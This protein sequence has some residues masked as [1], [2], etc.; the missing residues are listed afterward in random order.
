M[1]NR[2]LRLL[3]KDQK[4]IILLT[5]DTAQNACKAMCERRVGSVLVADRQGE[6]AG[7]FTGRDAVRLLGTAEKPSAATLAQVMTRNP[8]TM[9]PKRRAID[10]LRAM[11]EGGFRH[12]PVIDD[13]KIVGVVSSGDFKGME[14]EEYKFSLFE[15][16]PELVNRTLADII[17]ERRP[18]VLSTQ[19]AVA[20]ACRAMWTRKVGSVLVTD[21]ARL[22]KG[23]FTGRDAVR[24]LAIGETPEVTLLAK[25]M[26]RDPVSLGPDSPAIDALHAM[27]DGGFRHVPVVF[28][29]KILG[30]VARS[31]FSGPE[32]DR[33]DE[34]EHLAECIW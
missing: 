9:P 3:V 18:I 10:A 23:I 15:H 27:N 34:E 6:L 31:D 12:I 26:T 4:P 25:A 24:S 1:T 22:L 20:D 16:H 2:G 28:R 7:I 19:D 11:S 33:L 30:V 17:K 21:S 8:T 29:D 32:I 5:S 14:I 13:G